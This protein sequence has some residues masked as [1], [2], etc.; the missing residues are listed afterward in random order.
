MPTGSAVLRRRPKPTAMFRTAAWAAIL[1]TALTAA[2]P[3]AAARPADLAGWEAARWG[4]TVAD[5]DRAFGD[6][7]TRLDT[8]WSFGPLEARRLIADA[9][10]GG[11]RFTAYLQTDRTTGRLAQV[12][13][14]RRDA[15]ATPQAQAD[16]L[17]ALRARLGPPDPGCAA[18]WRFAT[19]TVT[20]D[21]IDFRSDAL[22]YEDPNTGR[23]V[24]QP[25]RDRRRIVRRFLP[26][27]IV[28]R[29]TDS[30]RDDLIPPC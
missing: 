18:R 13:L 17:T 7:L 29:F 3:P 10:V 23:D 27:R 15:A 4:M 8:P 9:A 20:A 28:V 26:R 30:A 14:E 11:V 2:A 5:L 21:A 24:L 25:R 1:A 19:T 22:L 6:R 16:A 12:L